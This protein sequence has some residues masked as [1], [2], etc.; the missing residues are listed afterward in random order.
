MSEILDKTSTSVDA[1]IKALSAGETDYFSA[2]CWAAAQL[3]GMAARADALTQQVEDL[4]RVAK[5]FRQLCNYLTLV[6]M[7]DLLDEASPGSGYTFLD[8]IMPERR[9]P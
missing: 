8:V 5:A 3:V 4:K 6:D 9:Q 7:A 2:F 1:K